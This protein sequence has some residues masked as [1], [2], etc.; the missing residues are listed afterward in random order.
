[1]KGILRNIW[2]NH[3]SGFILNMKASLCDAEV[4]FQYQAFA[5]LVSTTYLL[6]SKVAALPQS[7][8]ISPA[9]LP[10]LSAVPIL[11]TLR[12]L[13]HISHLPEAWHLH[14]LTPSHHIPSALLPHTTT[15]LLEI[16][17]PSQCF[18]SPEAQPFPSHIPHP[19][20]TP[21]A[22]P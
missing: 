19:L 1:M 14:S 22:E 5:P 6:P 18:P 3:R 9:E 4:P 13:H 12:A 16:S 7:F 8:H 15:S 17:H 11:P 20:L 21:T 2:L 10:A